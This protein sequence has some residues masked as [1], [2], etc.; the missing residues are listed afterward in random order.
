MVE[1]A[2]EVPKWAEYWI[3]GIFAYVGVMSIISLVNF[4]LF[5]DRK[6]VSDVRKE[7][8]PYNRQWMMFQAADRIYSPTGLKVFNF[9]KIMLYGLFFLVF[10]P[11]LYVTLTKG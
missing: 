10:A 3:F 6:V 11:L 9:L 1:Q 2:V 8:T 4:Y 5:A 7:S